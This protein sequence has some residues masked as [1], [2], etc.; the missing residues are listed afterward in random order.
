MI[1][2]RVMMDSEIANPIK[3]LSNIF[4]Y[5]SADNQKLISV[6]V[7]ILSISAL[8]YIIDG[9]QN[10]LIMIVLISVAA[11]CSISYY[12]IKIRYSSSIKSFS[13]ERFLILKLDANFSWNGNS[14][15]VK[16]QISLINGISEYLD[17]KF[18]MFSI[19]EENHGKLDNR[20][21]ITKSLDNVIGA[22]AKSFL[23]TSYIAMEL[24]SQEN[25]S[26][27]NLIENL[28]QHGIMATIVD[29]EERK[30]I[31]QRL[32]QIKGYRNGYRMHSM[33]NQKSIT[34]LVTQISNGS[35]FQISRFISASNLA[36]DTFVRFRKISKE[37][38]HFK[39]RVTSILTRK[40]LLS[41]KG[42][43][44]GNTLKNKLDA[45]TELRKDVDKYCYNVELLLTVSSDKFYQLARII[46]QLQ[47]HA[48]LWGIELVIP[49]QRNIAFNW[50]N[51]N[52]M[53]IEYPQPRS[54]LVSFF[55]LLFE[56]RGSGIIIGNE[57][58]TGNPVFFDPYP[59]S[60]HNILVMG[61]TGSGKSFFSKILLTR[62]IVLGY[63]SRILVLDVL[64]EYDES[65]WRKNIS[66]ESAKSE[67]IEME[68]RKCSD[69][70]LLDHLLYAELF[71]KRS[72]NVPT[73]ILIEE[74]HRFFR[75]RECERQI[76]EMIKVSRHF[77][78]S[79]LIV[80]QDS[81]DFTTENG[82]KILNN[83]LN[84]FIFRNKLISNL[85][86]FG[87]NLSDY[88]LKNLHMSLSGGKNS[89]FSE[90]ILFSQDEMTKIKIIAS[91]W[92]I[93]NFS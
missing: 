40:R 69:D 5:R 6:V 2:M 30:R 78:T 34:L 44:I 32:S 10:P 84:I 53:L 85:Q 43:H 73:I 72:G 18:I 62:M 93:E 24:V 50:F 55:P 83:S 47:N 86:K 66:G 4:D 76:V 81:S 15:K 48:R 70:D 51:L 64:G 13:T 3:P 88:G 90:T 7:L 20:G 79:V 49:K 74:G 91:D 58:L 77:L 65:L 52:R 67:N 19:S 71:M 54:K 26:H 75:N 82:K 29:G 56:S 16:S 31:L 33:G 89:P 14:E 8:L 11:I 87:I 46:D 9:Y 23:N 57:D 45:A 41:E 21:P 25:D 60:S 36:V 12:L 39:R 42:R 68:I 92:E 35:L 63:V 38:P 61:E 27:L 37:N 80:S 22:G 59:M 28:E 17:Q 1:K